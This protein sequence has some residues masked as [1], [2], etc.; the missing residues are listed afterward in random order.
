MNVITI[1]LDEKKITSDILHIRL[2][3]N[4]YFDIFYLHVFEFINKKFP[5]STVSNKSNK[6]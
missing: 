6:K 3:I 1:F 4:N 2:K 5:L